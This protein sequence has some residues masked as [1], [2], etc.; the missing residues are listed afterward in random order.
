MSLKVICVNNFIYI[1]TNFV[2]ILKLSLSRFTFLMAV[3]NRN[4]YVYKYTVESSYK[5]YT[6]N[7]IINLLYLFY[8]I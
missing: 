7:N 2:I 3:L 4:G 8:I 5:E 1:F 6:D